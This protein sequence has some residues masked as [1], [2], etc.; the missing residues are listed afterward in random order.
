M[1]MEG[2]IVEGE[3]VEG[4]IVEGEIVEA[5]GDAIGEAEEERR[6]LEREAQRGSE[7]PCVA[8]SGRGACPV[9]NLMED[10]D[11]EENEPQILFDHVNEEPHAVACRRGSPGAVRPEQASVRGTRLQDSLLRGVSHG[12][13][14]RGRT[15]IS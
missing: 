4:E 7:E 10:V 3:I 13:G 11:K 9:G 12:G 5:V 14:T 6:R 8:R 2:E 1:N 15:G